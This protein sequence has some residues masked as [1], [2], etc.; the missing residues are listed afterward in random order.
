M[1]ACKNT[2]E[3]IDSSDDEEVRATSFRLSP[4]DFELHQQLSQHISTIHRVLK[5][6]GKRKGEHDIAED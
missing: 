4:K 6:M 3:V 5:K 2:V 1:A